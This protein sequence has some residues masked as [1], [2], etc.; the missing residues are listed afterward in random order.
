MRFLDWEYVSHFQSTLPDIYQTICN[1]IQLITENKII[2]GRACL[3]GS[4]YAPSIPSY[5]ID[6]CVTVGGFYATRIN[7]IIGILVGKTTRASRDSALPVISQN[8]LDEWVE[9]QAQLILASNISESLLPDIA[10]SACALSKKN[11]LLKLVEWNDHFL[12]YNE[13]VDLAKNSSFNEF[14]LVHNSALKIHNRYIY[15]KLILNDNVIVC[16]MGVLPILLS[17]PIDDWPYLY[18]DSIDGISSASIE[19]RVIS[20]IAEGWNVK[21]DDLQKKFKKDYLDEDKPIK[22]SIGTING[23]PVLERA[24]V[25]ARPQ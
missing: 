3:F 16:A 1:N 15:D 19:E 22:L 8:T 9:K 24:Y 2:I 21:K 11:T 23:Q 14:V 4:Q 17:D 20:A 12:S 18:E 10:L 25:I 7:S 5:G 13:L 6:G